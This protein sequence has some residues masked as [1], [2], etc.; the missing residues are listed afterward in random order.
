MSS[1]AYTRQW[2]VLPSRLEVCRPSAVPHSMGTMRFLPFAVLATTAG[3]LGSQWDALPERWVT[4]WGRGGVPDGY[5]VKSLGGVF[6]PLVVAAVLAVLFEGV[7]AVTE[8]STRARFPQLARAYGNLV[9]WLSLGVVSAMCGVGLMLPSATPPSPHV[10]IGGALAT[11]VLALV[12]GAAGIASATR[13]MAARGESLPKGYSPLLYRNPEDPRLIVP[14]LV[15]IGWTLN[16]AHRAAWPL[17]ALM[18]LP[19]LVTLIAVL[20][21]TR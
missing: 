5:A 7:A 19:A 13:Q 3:W 17:L 4:H 21:A 16:F 10:L 20:V 9:R 12:A 8:Y 14:K 18:L 11:V 6:S 15:G 2:T 1:L